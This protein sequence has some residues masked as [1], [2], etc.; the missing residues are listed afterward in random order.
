MVPAACGAPAARRRRPRL[1]VAIAAA[2][3]GGCDLESPE[4]AA[5]APSAAR[6]ESRE[7][8][9]AAIERNLLAKRIGEASLVAEG[10]VASL[11]EDASAAAWF[12]RVRVAQ[13]SEPGI[14]PSRKDALLREARPALDRALAG[15]VDDD[16][17][18]A[19]AASVAET[20]GDHAAAAPPWERLAARRPDD[21]N[22]ALRIA[23]SRWRLGDAEDAASRFESA[24]KRWPSDPMVA[25]AYGEFLLEQGDA[26]AGLARFAD[27]RSLD[28]DSVAF[29]IREANWL[30]RLGR[31]GDA[32]ALLTALP[33]ADQATLAA[34]RE[35]AASWAALGRFDRAA[36]AW[37]VC[38]RIDPAS[39]ASIEAMLGAA[40]AWIAAGDRPRAKSWIDRI[41]AIDP[42]HAGLATIEARW[43]EAGEGR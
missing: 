2:L 31:S 39:A 5:T 30:R 18:L 25:A 11:P 12:A 43:R 10:L 34:T 15:G 27:A 33:R 1:A 35:T 21:P 4:P 42:Q 17:T 23:L 32:I 29:R 13:A 22:P 36:A 16:E 41:A 14:D 26:T 28:P 24:R 9:I 3:L 19:L 6:P 20:L 40:E 8:A 37:E 7:A 38:L